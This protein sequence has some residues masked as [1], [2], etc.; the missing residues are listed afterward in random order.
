MLQCIC[1]CAYR[2]ALQYSPS[3][4]IYRSQISLSK[5]L[6]GGVWTST[7]LQHWRRL[8]AATQPH[9]ITTI[10]LHTLLVNT[11]MHTSGLSISSNVNTNHYHY[12]INSFS[13]IVQHTQ[14]HGNK[15]TSSQL[16]TWKDYWTIYQTFKTAGI[17][18]LL[19]NLSYV[20][21]CCQ[22]QFH[23]NQIDTNV[24]HVRWKLRYT[25]PTKHFLRTPLPTTPP[26]LPQRPT[27]HTHITLTHTDE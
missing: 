21:F 27:T 16:V 3:A 18:A 4:A 26:P 22:L 19:D 1:V 5:L 10:S 14:A 6:H 25:V 24:L 17:S 8:H 20:K 9:I 15:H 2:H 11:L 7:G 13:F 12:S 23:S